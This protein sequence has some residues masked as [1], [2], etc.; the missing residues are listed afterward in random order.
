MCYRSVRAVHC[1][2]ASQKPGREA[3]SC[4]AADAELFEPQIAL[5]GKEI[6]GVT[7]TDEDGQIY[8]PATFTSFFNKGKSDY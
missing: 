7:I 1:P 3:V 8:Q 2:S 4:H 5:V 6:E